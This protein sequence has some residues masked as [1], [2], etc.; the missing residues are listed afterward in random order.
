MLNGTGCIIHAREESVYHKEAD[1]GVLFN[2]FEF[3]IDSACAHIPLQLDW[4]RSAQIDT[5]TMRYREVRR[6]AVQ[7]GNARR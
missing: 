1:V 2:Y 4:D 5:Q 6:T 7:V 3:P